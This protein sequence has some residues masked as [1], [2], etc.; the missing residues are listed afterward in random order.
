MFVT[1]RRENGFAGVHD[2]VSATRVIV[3]SAYQSRPELSLANEPL[4]KTE[5]LPLIG[6]YHVLNRLGKT[7]GMELHVGFDARLLRR[8]WICKVAPGTPPQT[9]R[10]PRSASEK[11]SPPG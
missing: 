3:E 9:S 11:H 8:V 6:P 10:H 1:A 4:P 7:D 5:S 2:L